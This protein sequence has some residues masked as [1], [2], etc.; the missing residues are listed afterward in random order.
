MLCW[1]NVDTRSLS[2]KV[3]VLEHWLLTY[4]TCAICDDGK[5]VKPFSL[6]VQNYFRNEP[7]VK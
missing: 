2:M 4:I 1:Y 6:L 7:F 3:F 5:I